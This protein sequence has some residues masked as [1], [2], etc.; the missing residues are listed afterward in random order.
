MLDGFL[1][2][3]VAAD[4]LLVEAHGQREA[5]VDGAEGDGGGRG[6]VGG[7]AEQELVRVAVPE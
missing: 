3:C 2:L 4:K 1:G 7:E 6:D 5:V